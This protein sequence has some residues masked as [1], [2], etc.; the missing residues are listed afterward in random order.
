MQEIFCRNVSIGA[1]PQISAVM[2]P[3]AGGGIF[4]AIT[5]FTAVE[6]ELHVLTA[7]RNKGGDVE[8]IIEEL[9]GAV[10]LKGGV[11]F[12]VEDDKECIALIKSS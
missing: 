8:E 7:R 10:Q 1:A 3:C 9:G 4:P 5:D 6:Y 12:R 2:G 11:A